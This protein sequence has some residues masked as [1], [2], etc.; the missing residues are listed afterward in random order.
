M[1][2]RKPVSLWRIARRLRLIWL[3]LPLAVALI[4]GGIAVK[5]GATLALLARDGITVEGEV[6]ARFIRESR[7]SDGRIQESQI[8]RFSYRP[9]GLIEPII[10]EQSVSRRLYRATE[11]G[12]PVMV[13]Y[14]GSQPDRASVDPRHER[15]GAMIF[16]A[17]G[18]AAAV[19]ALGLGWWM[20]G[21]KLGILRALRHGEMREARV[22]GFAPTEVKINGA[23]Q[24]VLTWRDA[25]GDEGRS[26]MRP[27]EAFAAWPEGSVIVVYIDPVT[28]QGWWEEQI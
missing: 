28:G 22:T 3:A 8:L 10:K 23:P 5:T 4:F 11:V 27:R 17:V 6:V 19:I 12:G 14:A 16:G 26:M 1:I 2:T 21:R 15:M 13:T 18:A 7:D 9:E 24:V 25:A 20:L